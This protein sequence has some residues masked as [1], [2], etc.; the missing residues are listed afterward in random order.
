[1]NVDVAAPGSP[2]YELTRANTIV[3]ERPAGVVN[4][5]SAAD[6]QEA[7]RYAVA[8]EWPVA[9][10]ATGHAY[11]T[12][13]DGALLINTRPMATVSIDGDARTARVEA[14]VRA[15]SLITQAAH[16][17]LAPINGAAPTVG[18]VGFTLG[19]GL[20]PLGRRYGFAVDHV[21]SLDIVTADGSVL[22]ASPTELPELFWG[23]RGSRGNLG[24]V[25]ALVT[26]LV[27]V[28]HLYGGGLYFDASST[29][30]VLDV[31][32][33]WVNTVPDAMSTS[34]A[35]LRLPP[36]EF[37][38]EPIRGKFVLHVRIAYTGR[39]GE[40]LVHP[41]RSAAP[42]LIDTLDEMPYTSVGSIHNDPTEP[43]PFVEKSALLREFS[44]ETLKILLDLAGPDVE[45]P[46]S[47]V[48][49]RHLGGALGRAPE[50]PSAVGFRDA[51]FSV[52]IGTA[53]LPELIDPAHEYHA[54]LTDAL[55]PWRI[56]GPFVSFLSGTDTDP[57]V[58]AT[59]YE[60]D[61]YKRLRA[62]K[63]TF[64][65]TNLFRINHNIPPH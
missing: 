12:P 35:L 6:V 26:D 61:D 36:L 1:M 14:G 44:A 25:T 13:A 53:G 34:F 28:T 59:A 46:L 15:G 9:V 57:A 42:T 21:R 41:L 37:I 47:I 56:G 24:V 48:E 7:V 27:P 31:Y 51:A 4:A 54:H 60:P 23:V 65:P 58:V 8:E 20:G 38:P 40:A 17:G 63:S 10:Q 45:A 64:D 32:R 33:E 16:Y 39:D 52:F 55:S 11:T 49:L 19:G 2:G 22:T 29:P 62:L 5:R 30:R 50:R 18:T 43:G 3:E